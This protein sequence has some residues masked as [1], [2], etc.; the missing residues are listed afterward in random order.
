MPMS[1]AR[2]VPLHQGRIRDAIE[3]DV[4]VLLDIVREMAEFENRTA[5]VIA[6]PELFTLH[7]F[8]PRPY[9]AALLAEDAEGVALGMALY[10]FTFSTFVGKP[11]LYI[12]DL[13]VRPGARRTGLG[14]RFIRELA[15]IARDRGCGR[16]QWA[17]L[18]LNEQGRQFCES[19]GAKPVTGWGLM[20]IGE[21]QILK[22]AE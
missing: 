21:Q 14:R 11:S 18:D 1:Q 2:Q 7:M 4:P 16:L 19:W 17:V 10:Y 9:A 8:G 5:N 22:L 6:D 13:F 15:R 3:A 20:R 12:E